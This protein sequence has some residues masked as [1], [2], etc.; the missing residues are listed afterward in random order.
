MNKKILAW[1][2][3]ASLSI[4]S[5]LQVPV[6]AAS[7]TTETATVIHS[8]NLR[9]QPSLSGSHIRYLNTGEQIT[10]MDQVNKYWYKVK[11]TNGV[12]G[13]VTTSSSY[14]S[15]TYKPPSVQL[16]P[17]VA[18][19]KVID[20][21]MKYLGTPYQF[22]SSRYDTNTFDCSDFVR[23]AFSDSLKLSLPFDSRSQG[24]FVQTVGKTTTD[25][26]RLKPG[27]IMFFMSYKGS[28][29][30]AYDGIDK[31]QQTITHDG[32]YLG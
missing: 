23:Q 6:W 20:A 16:A 2:L 32:I 21:G 4:S 13:Y 9:S 1:G 10:I 12:T 19:Q 18:A 24:A 14:I 8:A 11:D 15:T 26:H 28:K 7:Q 30:S 3:A 31:S 27:D 5:L 29:A 17:A 25:W 22:G